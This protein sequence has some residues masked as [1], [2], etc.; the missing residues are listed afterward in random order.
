MILLINS[1]PIMNLDYAIENMT[2][3]LKKEYLI[4]KVTINSMYIDLEQNTK[5]KVNIKDRKKRSEKN[6][7]R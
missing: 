4:V 2:T 7:V 6:I 3:F 5:I 1:L